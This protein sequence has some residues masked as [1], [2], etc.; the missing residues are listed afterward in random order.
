[1]I[2]LDQLVATLWFAEVSYVLFTTR[3]LAFLENNY[4]CTC[5]A[6]DR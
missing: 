6:Q 2:S 3:V 1:M 5:F 4:E